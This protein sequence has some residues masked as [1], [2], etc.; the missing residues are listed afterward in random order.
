MKKIPATFA[1]LACMGALQA[2]PVCNAPK[3]KWLPEADIK[4]AMLKQG[5][6]IRAFTVRNGCYAIA[7]LDKLGNRFEIYLDPATGETID[8]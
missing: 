8:E 5:F 4:M 1:M 6:L 2:A 3:E 7:G